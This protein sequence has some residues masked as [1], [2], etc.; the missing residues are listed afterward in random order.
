MSEVNRTGARPG[1]HE[2]IV[3]NS[4]V[5]NL[6]ERPTPSSALSAVAAAAL[7][8]PAERPQASAP[9]AWAGAASASGRLRVVG[10][11]GREPAGRGRAHAGLVPDSLSDRGNA[12]LFAERYRDEFRFVPGLGWYR[13]SGYR[14]VVDEGEAV[15]WAAGELGEALAEVDPRG[16][17][18]V[19]VL[20]GHRQWTLS[21]RGMKA[22]LE[23]VKAAPAMVLPA[24]VL[25]AAP[26]A[27]CTPG[28]VVDLVSGRVGGGDGRGLHS[29]ATAVPVCAM[30]VPRWER[31]L[32]GVFGEGEEGAELIG[33]VQRL[34]GYSL[35]GDVGAQ[36]LPFLHGPGCNGKSVLLGVVL[37]LL[38]DYAD[39]A[40]PGFLMTR[41]F[42][43]HPADLAE[44]HGRRLVVC[45]EPRAE[46]R[47]DEAR[48]AFLTGGD[49]IKAR[50]MGRGFFS[51]DPTHKL[52]L[53]GNHRPQV[54]V[55]GPALWRRIRLVPLRRAV[56][57]E[58]R[59]AN[60]ADVLV[61]DEGPGI[62]HWMVAGAGRYLR[63]S[64]DL[65][66]PSVVRRAT[67]AYADTEDHVGRFLAES[68]PAGGAGEGA[69]GGLY[70]CYRQWCRLEGV[71]VV[72]AHAFAARAR[73]H[74]R[75]PAANGPHTK[76]DTPNKDLF[77]ALSAAATA[78][79]RADD[80]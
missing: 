51:F 71:P 14:W 69:P 13:W 8:A 15:L 28:G 68:C 74:R 67:A 42:E 22:M 54:L 78:A 10:V 66:G 60:L 47:L 24:D 37:R 6:T 53:V 5:H 20:R 50:R 34:L 1:V 73:E 63:G 33:Y 40:P 36:V 35:T 44:L 38:G 62:L 48:V 65:R 29:R 75:H 19:S 11:S 17:F 3:H 57:D 2:N 70:R 46:D 16:R 77:R 21:T 25:D 80:R 39:A 12:K 43:E 26:F 41:S 4:V 79:G 76:P 58:G 30:P 64:R 72:S 27:L 55:G 56:A 31:F 18:G 45:A 52:W 9:T 23:Q 59:V 49:R 7:T 61:A 32:R